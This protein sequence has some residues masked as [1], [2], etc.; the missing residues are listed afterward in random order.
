M[1]FFA[2]IIY[3]IGILIA[4][5][6]LLFF[7]SGGSGAIIGIIMF[8]VATP[9]ITFADGCKHDAQQE[10]IEAQ[11][12]EQQKKMQEEMRRRKM[13]EEMYQKNR[14]KDDADIPDA[15]DSSEQV[16]NN[17]NNLN[18]V[19]RTL[20]ESNSE[21]DLRLGE[22][23]V[24]ESMINIQNDYGKRE[25]SKVDAN[26]SW[27]DYPA[28]QIH[29]AGGK[30]DCIVSDNSNFKT[31]RGL[32]TGDRISDVFNIYGHRCSKSSYGGTLMYEYPYQSVQGNWAVLRFATQDGN[33]I[34]YISLRRLTD[35]DEIRRLLSN[36][37]D[38]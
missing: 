27:Y 23:F 12:Q 18:N 30:V 34:S 15:P 14:K 2:N 37:A 32:G 4:L 6:G 1:E 31:E 25:Q 21:F 19:N 17:L 8:A 7:R 22:M 9:I 5:G 33:T 10:K 28:F 29:V 36:V 38:N 3:V 35:S 16:Y 11:K 13:Q 24:D 26:G 20:N